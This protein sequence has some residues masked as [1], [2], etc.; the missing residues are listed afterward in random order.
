M[1]LTSALLYCERNKGWFSTRCAGTAFVELLAGG[2]WVA[3]GTVLSQEQGVCCT[4]LNGAGGC[5]LCPCLQQLTGLPLLSVSVSGAAF[6]FPGFPGSAQVR[7]WQC[8]YSPE[9]SW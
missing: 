3:G 7:S 9:R 4:L 8:V 1:V 6:T 2:A 5:G